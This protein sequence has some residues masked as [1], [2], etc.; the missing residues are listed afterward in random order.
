M[1]QASFPT[2]QKYTIEGILGQGSMGAVYKAHHK[3]LGRAVALKVPH[4]EM[5]RSDLS[6]ER[7]LREG[8]ALAMLQHP[9]IVGVYDAGEEN[10]LPYLAMEF[11][12]GS[13]L[14]E[15]V[16]QSKRLSFSEVERIAT[17]IADAL[18]YIHEKGILHRDLKSSNVLI[19]PDGMVRVT[20]FGIA[21]VNA[22][23]TITNGILGTPAYM[24]PEQARGETIDGRSD[25]Y[26]LGVIMYEALTGH[27]P[28]LADNGLAIIQQI[29]HQAPAPLEKYRPDIPPGLSRIVFKCLEKKPRAR[30]TS[31][32][33]LVKSLR[34]G[35]PPQPPSRP[36]VLTTVLAY[37][38]ES[39][40]ALRPLLSRHTASLSSQ[41]KS[42][43][44][45]RPLM[46]A[47]GFA[48]ILT[49]GIL[50]IALSIGGSNK[51][52]SSTSAADSTQV[53]LDS[54][55]STWT[56]WPSN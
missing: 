3:K 2:F 53:E 52:N 44:S 29:I 54:T 37:L 23:T 46:I 12:E 24:S 45:D 11:I 1:G 33:E 47:L 31:S 51:R 32:Q 40:T 14:S 21:Q 13:T 30:Y 17:Q 27:I 56:P 41:L 38:N 18:S 55:G 5:M 42:I 8:R 9:H 15:H 34:K 7:F 19:S 36:H 25:I 10:D 4:L 43:R 16:R 49:I 28:F 39:L 35:S 50:L 6:K 22:Q 26:S 48:G 20:D